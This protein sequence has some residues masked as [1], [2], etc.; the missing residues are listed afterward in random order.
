MHIKKFLVLML[1]VFISL[2]ACAWAEEGEEAAEG[3]E[4]DAA[5]MGP[6]APEIG[7]YVLK[8]DITTNVA[9]MN[10]REKVHYVRVQVS[11]ML[12]DNEDTALIT[13]MEPL[14]K[15][16]VISIIGSKEYS[17]VASSD[18]REKIRIACRDRLTAIMNEKVG[19][20]V[21]DDVLF[22]NYMYQ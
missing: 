2:G 16:A 6:V 11:L 15:D 13:E 18:G 8:P 5:I 22:L 21:I 14:I 4:E 1:C 20:Q 3:G 7:Y 12:G 10:P 17:E 9:T 19:R